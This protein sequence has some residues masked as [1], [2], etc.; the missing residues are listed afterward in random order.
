[1]RA[2]AARRR[3]SGP[4]GRD[5]SDPASAGKLSIGALSRATEISVETLRT[6]ERRYGYPVPERKPS[7]HRVYPTTNVP[8]LRRIAQALA[9]GHRAA[10]VVTASDADLG[11]L[12]GTAQAPPA[13]A[14]AALSAPPAGLDDLLRAVE[15]FDSEALTRPLLAEWARLGPLAFLRERIGPLVRAVGEAWEQGRLEVRHEHFLSERMGDLL[16]TLRMPLEERARGPL[17]V[18]TT[19][20]GEAHGLGVQM[21]ALLL[22]A[23]GYRPLSLGTETPIPQ[24]AEVG[25]EMGARAVGVSIS[26]S[27]R[28]A[29]MTAQ[30]LRLRSLLPRRIGLLVGGDGAPRARAG[31]T[32][33]QDLGALDHWARAL[34]GAG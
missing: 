20:P 11:E 27:S 13:P 8:R 12:L 10:E 7:G 19:L 31:V 9:Q 32:V 6:W 28:G 29:A 16:R 22:A 3:G 33:I 25:R 1:M 18:L 4:G 24:V 2:R 15:R 23:C 5:A 26:A 21:V 17:M 30:V 34:A 14:A